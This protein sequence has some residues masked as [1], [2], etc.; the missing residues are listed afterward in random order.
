[1]KSNASAVLTEV[2]K[3]LAMFPVSGMS[4]EM[5]RLRVAGYVETLSNFPLEAVHYVCARVRLGEY[6]QLNR[7]F[8]PTVAE[9]AD[10][11]RE[12]AARQAKFANRPVFRRLTS[13]LPVIVT[14]PPPRSLTELR[15]LKPGAT[16]SYEEAM[17][18]TNGRPPV[19]RFEDAEG[20]RARVAHK[21]VP[22]RSDAEL[23]AAIAE[24]L[25]ASSA[26]K[27]AADATSDEPARQ[28][29]T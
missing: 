23:K 20:T 22:A 18:L 1:M 26:A 16:V 7:A 28:T 8:A 24:R 13:S 17:I 3:L 19:G 2:G 10:L 5:Q 15:A 21:A 12:Q 4:E 25:R 29:G 27:G 9:L 6:D 14:M 11:V